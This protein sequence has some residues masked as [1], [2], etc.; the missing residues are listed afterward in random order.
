MN[1]EIYLQKNTALGFSRGHKSNE[2]AHY[3]LQ[4]TLGLDRDF[5]LLQPK[6][7]ATPSNITPF[8][9]TSLQSHEPSVDDLQSNAVDQAC[10]APEQAHHIPLGSTELAFLFLNCSPK[11]FNEWQNSGGKVQQADLSLRQKLLRFRRTRSGDKTHA[12]NLALEWQHQCLPGLV[13]RQPTHPALAKAIETIRANP[14][15]E[16]THITLAQNV[17]L[18]PSRFAHV[19]SEQMGI[20]IRN[21]LLWQRLLLALSQLRQGSSVTTAAYASGFSDCAHL[22]RSFRRV[23]GATPTEMQAAFANSENSVSAVAQA[24]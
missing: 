15:G 21:Y 18:S 1:A 19:F 6:A 23:F 24:A 13:S 14:L 16:H 8:A 12:A 20:P 5:V 17:S 10:F 7:G 4:L 2:H 22:S 9:T 3:A 11:N